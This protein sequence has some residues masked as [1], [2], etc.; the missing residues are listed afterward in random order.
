M[1]LRE[2]VPGAVVCPMLSLTNYMVW[3][4]QMKVLLRFHKVREAIEPGTAEEDMNDVATDLMFQSIPENLILQVGE[5]GSPKKIW[6]AIKS[7]KLYA[8][9]V[10]EAWL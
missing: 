1:G 2:A 6:G 9:R 8:D 3:A 4:M 7:R 5:Q 10:R